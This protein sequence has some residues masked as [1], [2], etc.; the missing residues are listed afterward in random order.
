MR[1]QISID[2]GLL[3]R[4]DSCA[5]SSY[6]TRSGLITAALNSYLTSLEALSAVKDL[7]FTARKIA[8]S[9]TI[10]D[11]SKQKLADFE[12]LSKLLIEGK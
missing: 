3:A 12:R 11:D 2:E 6:T 8:D 5:E 1:V 9:N 10:D 7:A 4:V